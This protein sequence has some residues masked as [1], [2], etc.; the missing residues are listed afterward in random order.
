MSKLS[1]PPLYKEE[2]KRDKPRSKCLI[3]SLICNPFNSFLIRPAKTIVILQSFN[4]QNY[5]VLWM[6]VKILDV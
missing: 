1:I 4:A 5:K 3:L 2:L 6:V